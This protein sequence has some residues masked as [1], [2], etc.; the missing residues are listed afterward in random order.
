[1]MLQVL[2]GAFL[3]AMLLAAPPPINKLALFPDKSAWCEAKNITQIVGHSGCEAKSIQNRA[4]LGQCFSYSVPNTFPQSTESLVH[5]DSCM[6]AQ[7]MWE[8]V[9]LECPGHEE[10]P[11][12]DKLVEKILHC[13][14][15]ACGKEPSHGLSV[16]VQ[17]EDAPG[18]QPGTRP[19]PHPGGQTPE[20]ED[21]PGAPHVEEEG[22]ED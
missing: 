8:I 7:S 5:C 13:S 10:V 14:C 15:Q 20:P 16:Y 11:R 22:A 18:S 17:G 9:T 19:H 12:V 1:M 3:P 2:V 6:P 4:C 21:P